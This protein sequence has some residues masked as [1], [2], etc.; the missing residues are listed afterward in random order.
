MEGL[1]EG[2]GKDKVKN[3]R[4][5]PLTHGDSHLITQGNKVDQMSFAFGKVIVA[6][7]N[8]HLLL[9]MPGNGFQESLLHNLP[10]IGQLVLPWIF[11][12]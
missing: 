5:S 8:R 11:P 6:F 7:L 1:A 12:G 9:Y 2:L 3:I 4:C 10:N